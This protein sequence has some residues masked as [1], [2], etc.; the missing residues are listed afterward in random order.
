MKKNIEERINQRIKELE[1][2]K[3]IY[4]EYIMRINK[5][6]E[7]SKNKIWEIKMQIELLKDLLK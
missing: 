7:F 2:E 4:L 3:N 5:D 1:N 6:D